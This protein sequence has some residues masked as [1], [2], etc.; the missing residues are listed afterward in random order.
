MLP[1]DC[2]R[3]C[4]AANDRLD[5][6]TLFPR[7]LLRPQALKLTFVGA[8]VADMEQQAE[9][10]FDRHLRVLRASSCYLRLKTSFAILREVFNHRW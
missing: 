3:R 5:T 7:T 2:P 1:R 8:R 4:G 9:P 6:I 10:Q